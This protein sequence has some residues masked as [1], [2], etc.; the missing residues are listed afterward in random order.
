MD[1]R[2]ERKVSSRNSILAAAWQLIDSKGV[3][4]FSMRELGSRKAL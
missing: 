1:G 3:D 4:G 2:N